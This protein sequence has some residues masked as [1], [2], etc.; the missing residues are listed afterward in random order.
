MLDRRSTNFVE[1]IV[2]FYLASLLLLCRFLYTIN[3]TALS[4]FCVCYGFLKKKKKYCYFYLSLIPISPLESKLFYHILTEK[5]KRFLNVLAR[6]EL[7]KG[8]N[9]QNTVYLR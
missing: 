1:G 5:K 8:L 4:F 6:G 7:T 9:S 3:F 2:S